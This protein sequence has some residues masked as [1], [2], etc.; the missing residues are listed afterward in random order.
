MTA[1]VVDKGPLPRVKSVISIMIRHMCLAKTMISLP[2]SS[3]LD[4]SMSNL[5]FSTRNT[6]TCSAILA[7]SFS[8]IFFMAS[9]AVVTP[10]ISGYS[11]TRS[12]GAMAPKLESVRV[13]WL[14]FSGTVRISGLSHSISSESYSIV[15]RLS[16]TARR[17]SRTPS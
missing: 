13:R 14:S 10:V 6:S 5:R 17:I 7:R 8:G 12:E 11:S 3:H 16:N 1:K 2:L 15:P 4:T 9:R